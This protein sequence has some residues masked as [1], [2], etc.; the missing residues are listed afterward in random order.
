MIL[1]KYLRDREAISYLTNYG[2][3]HHNKEVFTSNIDELL[4]EMIED[5][6]NMT[7]KDVNQ[8]TKEEK[9]E[10]VKYL[11]DK[12]A[13]LIK[14]RRSVWLIFGDIPVY[15]LQLFKIIR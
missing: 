7:G 5:A 2:S 10:V 1:Q 4:D 14:N 9:V 8:L 12:G 13:F 11:D 15:Y 3:N 6:V